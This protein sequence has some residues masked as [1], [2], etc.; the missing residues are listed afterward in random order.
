MNIGNAFPSK[1]LKASDLQ[2][3]HV[4]VTIDRVEMEEFDDGDKAIVYFQGKD[5]GLVLN[6][7]NANMIVEITGSSE[8]GEWKGVRVSLYSTK[9]D[10][11]GKRVDAI[12]VDT[13]EKADA[14]PAKR[15]APAAAKP[16]APASEP[17]ENFDDDSGIPF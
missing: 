7:T 9:V 12:R 11:Q 14:A 4:P 3:R 10:F 15:A 2:G 8:T 5:K 17:P 1:Y 16:A 13:A 6:K